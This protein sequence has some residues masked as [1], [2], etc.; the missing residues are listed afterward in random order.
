MN[1]RDPWRAAW[2]SLGANRLRSALTILGILIGVGSVVAVV[3]LTKSLEMR[4]LQELRRTGA[5]SFRVQSLIPY[6]REAPRR[7]REPLG[8]DQIQE[9][10]RLLPSLQVASPSAQGWEPLELRGRGQRSSHSWQA[11]DEQ[12]LGLANLELA[13]GRGFTTGDCLGRAPVAILGSAVAE[14]FMLGEA[15]LPQHLTLEGHEVEIIGILKPRLNPLGEGDDT[16]GVNATIFLPYGAFPSLLSAR[17][18]GDPDWQILMGLD[19]PHAAAEEALREALRQVRGLRAAE[20]DNFT[21]RADKQAEDRI[22]KATTMLLWAS[23]GLMSISLLVGGIGVMNIMLV[24]V[25]ERTREIGLRMAV[26]A[27][28]SAILLQFLVESVALC[29][30]GGALGL[31][32]GLLVGE[33]LAQVLFKMVSL[34]SL[35]AVLV[36]VFVPLGVGLFFGLWPARRA[37]RLDPIEALRSE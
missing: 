37:A 3:Q 16:W 26:G 24:T 36:A 25:T 4:I 14:R 23:T 18:L 30:G 35:G 10:R 9:L 22:Q 5:Y 34:P 6:D 17:I 27:R 11:V 2:R 8:R 33:V 31:V 15:S 21:L 28:R 19:Q 20:K 12:G 13:A 29:L 7:R 1:L 32:L